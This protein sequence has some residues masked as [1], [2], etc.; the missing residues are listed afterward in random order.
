MYLQDTRYHSVLRM[1]SL[2]AAFVLVFDSG[3]IAPA[4]RSLSDNA[5]QYVA[6]VVGVTASVEETEL[7]RMTAAITEKEL[8]LDAREQAIVER[9]IALEQNSAVAASGDVSTY[10]LSIILFIL[11]ALILLNYGLDFARYRK[12]FNE[13][14]SS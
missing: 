7:N 9:E 4:T 8:A 12:Q 3:L 5:Q 6:T 10:L 1:A 11:L 13:L 14:A 2:V